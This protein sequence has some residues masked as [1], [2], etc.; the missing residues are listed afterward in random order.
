M[1]TTNIICPLS[2]EI[3]LLQSLNYKINGV[4][5]SDQ[6]IAYYHPQV[7]CQH[8]MMLMFFHGLD[9]IHINAY[10]VTSWESNSSCK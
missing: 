3:S 9:I 4:N 10:I 7:R 8:N 2:L 6:L 1:N 5:L